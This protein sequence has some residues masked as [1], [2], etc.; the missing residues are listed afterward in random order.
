MQNDG[1][2]AHVFGDLVGTGS[3]A[4]I[5]LMFVICSFFA[6]TVPLVGYTIPLIR[7]VEDI[8]PDYDTEVQKSTLVAEPT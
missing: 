3:G 5:G 6:L 4:G 2:L 8:L 1:A 7:K